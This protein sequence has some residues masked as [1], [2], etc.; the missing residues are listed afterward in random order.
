MVHENRGERTCNVGIYINEAFSVRVTGNA[1]MPVT[2]WPRAEKPRVPTRRPSGAQQPV[3]RRRYPSGRWR[4][5]RPEPWQ[6]GGC[7]DRPQLGMAELRE[8][9]RV[10]E[11]AGRQWSVQCLPP[12]TQPRRGTAGRR[13]RAI[14][15]IAAG[16]GLSFHAPLPLMADLR[17]AWNWGSFPDD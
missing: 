17:N 4:S 6:Y 14:G 8:R 1:D 11:P 15:I 13:T 12:K 9:A 3:L 5:R 7:S 2:F 10:L 16:S